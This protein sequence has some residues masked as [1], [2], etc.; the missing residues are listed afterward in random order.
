MS[1]DAN[2]P[3]EDRSVMTVT[4]R[5]SHL[6]GVGGLLL[7]F[8]AGVLVGSRGVAREAGAQEE[9][10]AAREAA[11]ALPSTAPE[12]PRLVRVETEGRPSRGPSDAPVVIVEFTDYAC[13]FCRR[14]A[15]STLTPLLRRY[16]DRIHY[17]VRNFPI[18]SL[19]PDAPAAAEAAECAADQGRFWPYH[20]RLFDLPSHDRPSLV[21]LAR[22][23]GLDDRRFAR[24]LDRGEKAAV[25]A[26]D[27]REGVA[28]G[29][30]GTPTFFV[31]GRPVEGYVPVATFTSLIDEIL[32]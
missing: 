6:Y 23:V 13:P 32:Q 4:V 24:C 16:G 30:T 26:R 12:E 14:H 11:A 3:A 18:P 17:V 19:H 22:A 10:P 28:A 15:D 8:L 2:D 21:S 5:R 9:P 7:G 1:T 31:N 29:V 27:M 25:V 20:D